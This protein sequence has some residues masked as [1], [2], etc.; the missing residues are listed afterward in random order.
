MIAKKVLLFNLIL[1][2]SFLLYAQEEE[3]WRLQPEN[4]P[5][6]SFEKFYL[7]PDTASILSIKIPASFKDSK[8]KYDIYNY[9]EKLLENAETEI[10][11]DRTVEIPINL[12]EG[13]YELKFPELGISSG[14]AVQTRAPENPDPYFGIDG[15]IAWETKGSQKKLRKQLIAVIKESGVYAV[16]DRFSWTKVMK[17]PESPDFETGDG[18]FSLAEA[19]KEAG[20]KVLVTFHDSPA[21]LRT[22]DRRYPENLNLTFLQWV[23]ILKKFDGLWDTL[24]VWNEPDISFG[25]Y[26]PADQYAPILKTIAYAK[27]KSGSKIKL[28]GGILSEINPEFLRTLGANGVFDVAD[29]MSYHDY[30]PPFNFRQ[31]LNMYR[32]ELS[33]YGAEDKQILIS[34]AGKYYNIK[35]VKEIKI[36]STDQEK[37]IAHFIV[38][39]ALEGKAAGLL[40]YYPFILNYF[41]NWNKTEQGGMLK[42]D[43]SPARP[44]S[45]YSTLIR[46][47]HGMTYTGRLA[48]PELNQEIRN[49][50]F[51]SDKRALVILYTNKHSISPNIKSF[52]KFASASGIDGRKLEFENGIIRISDGIIYL[53]CE[54]GDLEKHL[55]VDSVAPKND[56]RKQNPPPIIISPSEDVKNMTNAGSKGWICKSVES[57]LKIP[58]TVY[59]MGD[60]NYNLKIYGNIEGSSEKITSEKITVSP[61]SSSRIH[62]TINEKELDR[63]PPLAR[64]IIRGESE[65]E[66]LEIQNAAMDIQFN[67]SLES[68]L[69]AFGKINRLNIEKSKSW[70]K[71]G[72]EGSEI[73]V[74]EKAS[75]SIMLSFKFQ[76]KNKM[77]EWGTP[78]LNIPDSARLSEKSGFLIKARLSPA[79][80]DTNIAIIVKEPYSYIKESVIPPDGEWHCV[81]ISC[82]SLRHPAWEAEDSNG[83]ADWSTVNEIFLG[84]IH[85]KRESL[86]LEISDFYIVSP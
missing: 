29:I 31:S 14:I 76:V 54:L 22:V 61:G 75:N 42:P 12:S 23:S 57:G 35:G 50:V 11:E 48:A 72:I 81:Y 26:L 63:L 34:E 1:T 16:R 86:D 77:D 17:N 18:Y 53:D 27:L 45:A 78:A 84:P 10:K 44:I 49:I 80:A 79:S 5:M 36:L 85:Y 62:L 7:R 37:E 58:V 73:K 56:G 28:C 8:L 15:V 51:R 6:Q 13:W 64:L 3:K 9:T 67:K 60:K 68:Q 71:Y 55:Q 30:H 74:T 25:N 66:K 52:F 46:K 38:S 82:E 65:D 20:L 40:Q 19:Y 43:L 4:W 59:N 2:L 41:V 32:K 83:K 24:E 69:K 47:I 21:Y 39:K 33:E 70:R